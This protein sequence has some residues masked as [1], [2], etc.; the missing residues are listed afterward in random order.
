M[1][2]PNVNIKD[3]LGKLSFLKNN[4]ALLVP[5]IIAVVGLL[6]LVPARLLGGGVRKE[7]EQGSLRRGQ[8][9][10]KLRRDL[11]APRG[12]NTRE[13]YIEA[14]RQDANDIE[15]LVERTVMREFLRY[16][17]FPD[18]NE[19]SLLLFERFS[20]EYRAGVDGMLA[21]VGAGGAPSITAIEEALKS[22]RPTRAPGMGGMGGGY[23]T[24]SGL[25]AGS[26]GAGGADYGGL[27][28][29][30]GLES[31][32]GM[33]TP[34][35]S[36][37]SPVNREIVNQVCRDAAKTVKVYGAEEN[38]AGYTFW[39]TW[40][41]LDRDTAYRDCWYWQ[42]GYWVV[43]DVMTTIQ[44]M[45][46]TSTSVIDSPVKRLTDVSFTLKQSSRRRGSRGPTMRFG[47]KMTGG[48]GA[49]NNPTYVKT[50]KDALTVPCTGR[51]TN[52]EM[53]IIQ[54]SMR[55]IVD[56]GQVLP[57][58]QQLC[59]AKE[60][61]FRGFYGENDREE[62]YE[63]NQISILEGSVNVVDKTSYAHELYYYGDG[64][65]VE[66]DMICEYVFPKVPA[67]DGLK[68]KQVLEDL[69]ATE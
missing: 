58:M 64:S 8:K 47:A 21:K 46:E 25:D 67:F 23:D 55:V 48:A 4:L 6:F 49:G 31:G 56:A 65:V 36:G 54:F 63:H 42:L 59:S 68:P 1:K 20:E 15:A 26:L 40:T 39:D 61:K 3:I 38:I 19:T 57:F 32:R 66:L 27:Y 69:E 10:T 53:D 18:T 9:I 60:H 11:S 44:K 24:M 43:E 30:G 50:A 45:N 28:G 62:T 2:T 35:L 29:G 51:V 7:M 34:R 52:E 12:V 17:I 22:A 33:G 14:L 13:G 5:V 37:L 41:F 16:D